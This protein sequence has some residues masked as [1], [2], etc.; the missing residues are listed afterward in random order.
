MQEAYVFDDLPSWIHG[1]SDADMAL[2]AQRLG[3]TVDEIR[4]GSEDVQ[5]DAA[6][7]A[8]ELAMERYGPVSPEKQ[9]WAAD[10]FRPLD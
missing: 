10:Q 5:M 7:E 3:V 8:G 9:A 1:I 4:N 2:I 6:A